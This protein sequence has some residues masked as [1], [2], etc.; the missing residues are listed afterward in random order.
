MGCCAYGGLYTNVM[1]VIQWSGSANTITRENQGLAPES[2]HLCPL[3]IDIIVNSA[4]LSHVI[5]SVKPCYST[6]YHLGRET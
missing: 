4:E 6:T 5:Q 1:T 3:I 2:S